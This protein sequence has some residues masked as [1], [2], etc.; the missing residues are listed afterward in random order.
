[1][2]N[3]PFLH[4]LGDGLFSTMKPQLQLWT[5][6]FERLYRGDT[7][8]ASLWHVTLRATG[9]QQTPPW[10]LGVEILQ[11]RHSALLPQI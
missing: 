9:L 6:I 2:E 11:H 4:L 10:L 5:E 1:M 3:R 8:L 7:M